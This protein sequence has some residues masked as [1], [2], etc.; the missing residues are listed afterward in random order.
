MDELE[1][2]HGELD[3]ANP[4]PG[5]FDVRRGSSLLGPGFDQANIAERLRIEP[6]FPDD[7]LGHFGETVS[8]G[9]V[10]GG[11][12]CLEERLELPSLPPPLVVG[13]VSI[14]TAA[15]GSGRSFGAETRVRLKSGSVEGGRSEEVEELAGNGQCS[16]TALRF[17]SR[18]RLVDEEKIDVRVVVEFTRSPFAHGDDG[19][20]DTGSEGMAVGY[21]SH[22]SVEGLGNQGIHRAAETRGGVGQVNQSPEVTAGDVYESGTKTETNRV[23]LRGPPQ[24]VG[25]TGEG[26]GEGP[27]RSRHRGGDGEKLRVVGDR[28]VGCEDGLK[29]L[30]PS[31][32]IES[33]RQ[34]PGVRWG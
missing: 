14:E 19:E 18:Y 11:R 6:T 20:G 7:A 30:R 10:S 32:G 27:A 22:R 15:E 2:L 8:Q 26:L 16:F 33:L 28:R 1:K 34:Q 17:A 31:F 5:T 23:A 12:P 4:A 29:P 21:R 13:G 25:V 3:V 24:Q 9:R